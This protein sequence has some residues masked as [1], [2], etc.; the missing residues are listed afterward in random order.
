MLLDLFGIG[1]HYPING[2]KSGFS[3]EWGD[4]ME[5]SC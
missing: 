2:A 4:W 1:Q 3:G 5:V